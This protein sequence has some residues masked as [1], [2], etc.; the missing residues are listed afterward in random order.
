M[1]KQMYSIKTLL[2]GLGLLLLVVGFWSFTSKPGKIQVSQEKPEENRFTKTILAEKLDEPMEFIILETGKIMF[3]ERKG[4][5]KMYNPETRQVKTIASIPV[6]TK[7]TSKEGRVTEGEDGLLGIVQDPNFTQNHWIYLYYSLPGSEAKNIL[8]R[9]ELRGEELVMDSK[10]VLLEIPTQRE[11]CCHTGGGMVFDAKGNLYLSTGDNTSPRATGFDPI[12]ER[13]ERGPWDAQKSS[14]NTNDL[15]GKIIRIHPEADGSYTIPEGNLFPKGTAKTRPE[16]YTM[17]HRNPWRLSIDS[18]T[19]YIYWGEVGPDAS[20][21]SLHRG[22]RGHD[23]FNQARKAGNFGWPHF[24]GDNKAY[25]D[26]DF[27]T[28]TSKAPFDPA[29]PENNSPN[30]TGLTQLPPVQKAFIWYPYGA[31]S[32]FPMLG[33]GGRSATGGPVFR[34]A[35]F[36]GAKRPF[37]DY[38]EGKWFIVDFMRGWIM[39]VTMDEQGNYQSMER[40]MP[41]EKFSSAIDMKFGPDGDLYILEYGSAWFQGNDNAR[42]VRIDY[43]AGNRKPIVQAS[44]DKKA[45]SLPLKIQLS[46]KGTKDYDRDALTY[47]WEI[48]SNKKAFKTFAEPN[49]TVTF[50]KPG[51]YMATLTVTDTKG[52]TN[53]QTLEIKA[54][55]EPPVVNL[56]IT[57]GNKTFFFPN[58]NIGYTVTVSD[59]EDGSLSNS[60]IT[61]AQVSMSIDYTPEGFDQVEIAMGHRSADESAG[62]ATGQKLM[63]ASDCKSC[64]TVDKKSVGPS[65]K[66]IALKYKNEASSTDYLAKKII[67]GGA[68]VWGE[69]AMSAHPQLSVADATEMAKYILSLSEEKQVAKKLPLKGNYVTAIPAGESDKGNYLLRAA[70]T[71]KGTSNV[72]GI[73]TEKVILLRNPAVQPETADTAKGTQ[74]NTTPTK[75][76]QLI[77]SG[78]YVGFRK[79]DLTDVKAIEFLAVASSRNEAAGGM[80]EVRLGSPTGK[81]L[82]Q[83]PVI[84]VTDPIRAMQNA[85]ASAATTAKPN[86]PTPASTAPPAGGGISAMMRRLAKNLQAP[87]PATT[88][89]HDVYFVFTNDKARKDQVIMQVVEIR[90][91]NNTDTNSASA[92]AVK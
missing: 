38:Y 22:P 26:F 9:Y 87:I 84:E 91:A 79:V 37:P 52:E 15:R 90:F 50:D 51:V 49:P 70:Y 56:T 85:Q 16:I 60:K 17:G 29:K 72:P 65:F 21:D 6:N 24:I 81:L 74:L 45:G 41:N 58:Q 32:E 30:N 40:F 77:G 82:G 28:N 88:G 43:N 76:F 4:N 92:P 3:V 78:S 2:Y 75:S 61:P 66:Q 68:G 53:S 36:V 5:L 42:I 35:D 89:I 39:V 73:T 64:H 80:V 83:T 63:D 10:K 34:K 62:L 11:Q 18:K 1:A 14:G 55:N 59:K 13:P 69:V 86:T 25:I 46:S 31:S 20:Q 12:D 71:D 7:Y 27:A 19:G 67:S 8:T 48:T 57:K 44:L 33:S 54:G 47:K 23:E